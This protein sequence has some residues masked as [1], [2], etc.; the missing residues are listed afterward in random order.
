M[1][2]EERER[3]DTLRDKLRRGAFHELTPEELEQ[4]KRM[5]AY[6]RRGP[7]KRLQQVVRVIEAVGKRSVAARKARRLARGRRAQ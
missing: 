4:T 3:S 6:V 1:G 5:V 2:P 7:D